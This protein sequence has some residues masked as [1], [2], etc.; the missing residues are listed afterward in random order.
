MAAAWSR[1]GN[2]LLFA[3][4][5]N[6]QIFSILFH[7]GAPTA[8]RPIY[9][10][11]KIGLGIAA[12]AWDPSNARL[13]VSFSASADDANPATTTAANGVLI[14]ATEEYGGVNGIAGMGSAPREI[15]DRTQLRPSRLIHGPEG[16][17]PEAVTFVNNRFQSQ[18]DV[19]DLERHH[20]FRGCADIFAMLCIT[21]GTQ[22]DEEEKVNRVQFFPFIG[23]S[24]KESYLD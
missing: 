11:R 15:S 19:N 14:F 22:P 16:L 8:P 9:D 20:P 18:L 12:M 10:T 23:E 4:K 1:D 5:D 2:E 7:S 17:R 21:W 24:F 13:A 6:S 3:E